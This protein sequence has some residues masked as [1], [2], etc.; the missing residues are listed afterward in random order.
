M[1]MQKPNQKTSDYMD[2][3]RELFDE[4]ELQQFR[5][6]DLLTYKAI[7][8]CTME[9]ART[10]FCREEEPT[11][12]KIEKIAHTIEAAEN[13]LKGQPSSHAS[14]AVA[15]ADKVGGQWTKNQNQKK[16]IGGSNSTCKRCNGKDKSDHN[17]SNCRFKD[18]FCSDCGQKGHIPGSPWC[19]GPQ[20][21]KPPGKGNAKAKKSAP[22][23]KKEKDKA[24]CGA[25]FTRH[26]S[27]EMP[28]KGISPKKANRQRKTAKVTE[29]DSKGSLVKWNIPT[30]RMDIQVCGTRGGH[31]T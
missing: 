22:A 14:K 4:A 23:Q 13:T 21:S 30:P 3:L 8:G 2:K 1:Y 24:G 15:Q 12:K 25:V 31:L 19:K 5:A 6:E 26:V 9:P 20:Q 18:S 27:A 11:I 7:Q 16:P 10:K 28:K 17:H 29:V